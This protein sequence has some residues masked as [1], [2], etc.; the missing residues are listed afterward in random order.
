LRSPRSLSIVSCPSSVAC[1]PAD[2]TRITEHGKLWPPGACPLLGDGFLDKLLPKSTGTE[3]YALTR[4]MFGPPRSGVWIRNGHPFPGLCFARHCA[5]LGPFRPDCGLGHRSTIIV[6]PGL[7]LSIVI[8]Y[9]YVSSAADRRPAAVQPRRER[10]RPI[11]GE[12]WRNRVV[13]RLGH[14]FWRA[15]SDA[16]TEARVAPISPL[17]SPRVGEGWGERGRTT[18][19]HSP[20][21]SS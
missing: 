11:G 18:G 20:H 21:R 15:F 9:L 10:S 8:K 14:R 3:S 6:R 5:C 16:P 7:E 12:T 1:P 19:R 13:H 17:P 4:R 2:G